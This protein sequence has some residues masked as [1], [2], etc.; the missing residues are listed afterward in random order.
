MTP[1]AP[2]TATVA[3]GRTLAQHWALASLM[4]CVTVLSARLSF[5]I[6][7]TPVPVTLQVFAVLLSGLVCGRGWGLVAQAQYLLLGA[8]GLHVFAG[9][10]FGAADLFGYTGG[11]LLSYPLAA[12]ATAWI[13]GPPRDASYGKMALACAAG[14]AIIYGLGCAWFAAFTH[15]SLLGVV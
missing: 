10:G 5:H 8:C 11:Y 15:E 14:L 7:Q 2:A 13:A 3:F 1:P 4:T 9:G 6:P 12:C